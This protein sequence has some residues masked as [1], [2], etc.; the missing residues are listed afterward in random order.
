MDRRAQSATLPCCFVFW[1]GSMLISHQAVA[2][3]C[4]FITNACGE[5][6]ECQEAGTLTIIN[7]ERG[8]VSANIPLG[9]R[10]SG[11]AIQP[12]GQ[13]LYVTNRRQFEAGSVIVL[14]T[15]TR[16]PL[17]E[18]EVDLYPMPIAVTP[19]RKRV[20]VGHS[21]SRSAAGPPLVVIDTQIDELIEKTMPIG[22]QTTGLAISPDGLTLYAAN[23]GSD[24]IAVVDTTTNQVITTIPT[25]HP[26][27]IALS[28]EGLLGYATNAF[29]QTVTRIDTLTNTVVGDPIP[30]GG[31]PL[32]I[33]ISHNGQYAFVVNYCGTAPRCG[34]SGTAL[35][36][37]TVTV[38]DTNTYLST[39][40]PIA[41]GKGPI[42]AAIN[43]DD[44]RLYVVNEQSHDVSVV[45]VG[46]RATVMTIPV[47]SFPAGIA[48]G[49]VEGGCPLPTPTSTSTPRPT[50]SPT[51]TPSPTRTGTGTRTHSPSA[52]PTTTRTSTPS[53]TST[54]TITPTPSVTASSS[55]TP[56]STP[57][58]GTCHSEGVV[59]VDD[60]V[61][62]LTV[63]LGSDDPG[64]CPSGDGDRNGTIT[65][66][67]VLAAITNALYGCGVPPPTHTN[68][69]THTRTVTRTPSRTSTRPETPTSTRTG[70]ATR[71]PLPTLSPTRTLRPTRTLSPTRTRTRVPT[72]T[73]NSA[74]YC[75]TAPSGVA[76]CCSRS[77]PTH[78]CNVF[79]PTFVRCFA[80]CTGDN[81][82]VS[83]GGPAVCC[84]GRIEY[85]CPTTDGDCL[86]TSCGF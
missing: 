34:G 53:L 30:V 58:V 69:P 19:D 59:S 80:Q 21:F 38:I 3:E 81:L 84:P 73:P 29:A 4:V 40:D 35:P 57:C 13:K 70:T 67:E 82:C 47:G 86:V 39:G 79:A 62:M 41:V 60:V 49:L 16:I 66:E 25:D 27:E 11:V 68:T 43:R 72:P 63:A 77:R 33:T 23:V 28:P 26:Y 20:F 56:T 55:A 14:D 31:Q 6:R 42:A 45:D 32:G 78:Q 71:T 44:T 17:A 76:A 46:A 8:V 48:I 36:D 64:R 5:D 83:G 2:E 50:R 54:R 9:V 85:S 7:A 75:R 24:D 1:L 22:Q 12:G 18:I 37:G 10:P 52:S 51:I 74:D 65:V 61:A 15:T